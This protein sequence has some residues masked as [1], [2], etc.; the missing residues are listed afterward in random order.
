[1][2]L[3]KF[4]VPV[5]RVNMSLP[6]SD[7]CVPLSTEHR[8]LLPCKAVALKVT[9]NREVKHPCLTDTP[10]AAILPPLQNIVIIGSIKSLLVRAISPPEQLPRA[11]PSQAV[12]SPHTVHSY[13][14]ISWGQVQSVT[15]RKLF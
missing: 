14:T 9:F 2:R 4:V 1:M 5:V 13:V 12:A 8:T 6:T 3:I 10:R 15:G 11:V 7:A